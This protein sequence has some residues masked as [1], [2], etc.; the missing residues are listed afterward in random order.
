[1]QKT[2][3]KL[4]PTV[5]DKNFSDEN[6]IKPRKIFTPKSNK[7]T[8]ENQFLVER[9]KNLKANLFPPSNIYNKNFIFL[10]MNP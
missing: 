7:F 5:L 8:N 2:Q 3:S 10:F 1:M 6:P 4:I 9:S